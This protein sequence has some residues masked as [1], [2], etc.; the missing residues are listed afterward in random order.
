MSGTQPMAIQR[1]SYIYSSSRNRVVIANPLC[2]IETLIRKGMAHGVTA[3]SGLVACGSVCLDVWCARS[4]GS[5]IPPKPPCNAWFNG[6]IP[7]YAWIPIRPCQPIC[8]S[9]RGGPAV[10]CQELQQ[11]GPFYSRKSTHYMSKFRRHCRSWPLELLFWRLTIRRFR[12][13]LTIQHNSPDNPRPAPILSLKNKGRMCCI[14][15]VLLIVL[16]CLSV[17]TNSTTLA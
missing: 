11:S 15:S 12:H 4:S 14:I 16:V 3:T 7:G 10:A 5:A 13:E 8:S 1:R 17:C 9:C 6:Q 2:N